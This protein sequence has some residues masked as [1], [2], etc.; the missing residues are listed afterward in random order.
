MQQSL[1]KPFNHHE[2]CMFSGELDTKSFRDTVITWCPACFCTRF[3]RVEC[4]HNFTTMLIENSNGATHVRKL[5]TKCFYLQSGIKKSEYSPNQLAKLP[6]RTLEQYYEFKNTIPRQ[7]DEEKSEFIKTIWNK[8]SEYNFNVRH[9]Q[10]EE[11]LNSPEW[12]LKRNI[13]MKRYNF[14]CQMCNETAT[15]VHHIT[16][17]HV[18]NEYHFELVP[19]CR[20]CHENWHDPNYINPN[21]YDRGP[22]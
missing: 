10:Y 14:V 12:K 16:Y 7:E 20:K 21:S 18:K 9:K 3:D 13:I 15:D 2:T 1:F 6:R 19:L 8:R 5:C 17:R 4:E 22:F 11:Y